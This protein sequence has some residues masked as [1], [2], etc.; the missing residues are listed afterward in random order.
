MK[1]MYLAMQCIFCHD[2]VQYRPTEGHD[3]FCVYLCRDCVPGHKTLY[4]Q[5][6]H[7]SHN[8]REPEEGIL[9]DSIRVDEY[10]VVRYYL[11]VNRRDRSNY[12]VIFKDAIGYLDSS[13]DADPISLNKP[14]CDID[15][16][17]E[18]PWKNIE[19]VKKKLDIWTTFS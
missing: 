8:K 19:L 1:P 18:L 10:Y 3:I 16:I 7:S 2:P 17:I 6:Y 9:A 13:P 14:V 15:S 12:S 5:L 11:P 4:R